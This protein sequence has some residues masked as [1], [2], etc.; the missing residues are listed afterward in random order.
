MFCGWMFTIKYL[1]KI[2]RKQSLLTG[3]FFLYQTTKLTWRSVAKNKCM[4]HSS[5]IVSI[6]R[7]V[8]SCWNVEDWIVILALMFTLNTVNLK[9]IFKVHLNFFDFDI[10]HMPFF[11]EH[12]YSY[13]I[14]GLMFWCFLMKFAILWKSNQFLRLLNPNSAAAI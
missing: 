3:Q 5:K 9:L 2:H 6:D 11:I 10:G 1:C 12:G 8:W 13:L 14:K 7:T 4:S